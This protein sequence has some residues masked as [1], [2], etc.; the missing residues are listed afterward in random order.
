MIGPIGHGVAFLDASQINA[1]PFPL[2]VQLGPVTPATASASGGTAIER[3][4]DVEPGFA[5]LVLGKAY[6]GNASLIGATEIVTGSA[7][8]Y[9]IAGST[10]AS[11]G[12]GAADFLATF[13]DGGLCLLPEAFSY[14]PSLRRSRIGC[15]HS[16]R[17]SHRS[18]CR[19]WVRTVCERLASDSGRPGCSGHGL[20]HECANHSV[21]LPRGSSSIHRASRHSRASR[22]HLTTAYGST[23]AAGAFRLCPGC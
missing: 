12:D 6:V 18:N 5:T 2:V 10:P 19:I 17:G 3:V 8:R 21:A 22:H 11:T 4:T 14:G 15:R 9:T 13:G 16:G 7:P 20:V 23:T 1:G